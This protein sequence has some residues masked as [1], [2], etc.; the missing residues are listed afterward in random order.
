M[1]V[2]QPMA[3]GLE[4]LAEMAHHEVDGA[5]RGPTNEAAEGVP[6]HVERQAGVSVVVERA[7]AFV[8]R[9]VESESLCDPLDGEVAE[10]L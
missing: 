3:G 4:I 1:L 2:G 8:A 9:N 5:A 7:E 10:L 6:T